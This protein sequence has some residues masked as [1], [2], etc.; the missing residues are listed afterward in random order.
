MRTG[1]IGNRT[2]DDMINTLVE[3]KKK[4]VSSLRNKLLARGY[5]EEVEYDAINIEPVLIYTNSQGRVIFLRHKWNS[6]ALIPIQSEE[7]RKII[8][9][10]SEKN[11][12]K[13]ETTDEGGNRW[14]KFDLPENESD[15]LEALG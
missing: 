9:L 3:P 15:A 5:S 7:D 13:F 1:S 4:V 14:L 11:F 2:A 12:M 6:I 10:S 8:S